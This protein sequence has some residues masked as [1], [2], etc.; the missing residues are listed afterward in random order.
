MAHP[1][2]VVKLRVGKP[3]IPLKPGWRSITS[4]FFWSITSTFFWST[5]INRLWPHQP[6][7]S[8]PTPRHQDSIHQIQIHGSDD[9]EGHWDQA[10][11]E[12]QQSKYPYCPKN[13]AR[14][15]GLLCVQWE[16]KAWKGKE[17]Q[18]P[19]VQSAT[20]AVTDSAIQSACVLS[21]TPLEEDA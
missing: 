12:Q 7:P 17:D 18:K 14:E 15:K 16:D 8:H 20:K 3:A 11:S 19:Y 9:H 5:Q 21:T 13:T 2:N 10:T 6:G 4:T 1:V